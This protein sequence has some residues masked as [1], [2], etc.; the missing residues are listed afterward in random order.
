MDNKEFVRVFRETFY[1][2]LDLKTNWGKEQVKNMCQDA[3]ITALLL[4]ANPTAHESDTPL[5]QQYG[6]GAEVDQ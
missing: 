5:G 2:L 6:D 1:S 3:I 4:T